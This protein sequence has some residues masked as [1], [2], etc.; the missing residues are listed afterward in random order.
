METSYQNY[1]E[2]QTNSIINN[3]SNISYSTLVYLFGDYFTYNELKKYDTGDNYLL[4]IGTKLY[5]GNKGLMTIWIGR[6][7][8]KDIEFMNCGFELV[9][10]LSQL[11][12]EK[13]ENDNYKFNYIEGRI[14]L[15]FYQEHLEI[16]ICKSGKKIINQMWKDLDDDEKYID[17][18]TIGF[19]GKNA[20]TYTELILLDTNSGY[21]PVLIENINTSSPYSLEKTSYDYDNDEADDETNDKMITLNEITNNLLEIYDKEKFSQMVKNL[22]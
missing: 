15:A 12:Y 7:F 22:I 6:E 18:I 11:E 5:E 8:V 9:H 14:G 13:E 17:I 1:I 3:Y 2:T 20:W 16:R 19:K 21:I 10:K 4:D